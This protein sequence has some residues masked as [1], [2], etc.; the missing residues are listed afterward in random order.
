MPPTMDL[1]LFSRALDAFAVHSPTHLYVHHVQVFMEVATHGRRSYEEIATALSVSPSSVSRIA[2]SLSDTHRHGTPGHGLVDIE[3][4]ATMGRRF[5]LT[6][7]PKGK[8][9]A[10]Q[11]ANL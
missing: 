2:Q 11:I 7:S 4:D 10:R 8:A 9:L 3:R 6:L 1:A 5:V